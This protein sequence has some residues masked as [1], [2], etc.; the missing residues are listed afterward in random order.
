MRAQVSA[1]RSVSRPSTLSKMGCLERVVL[2]E[3]LADNALEV[4]EGFDIGLRQVDVVWRALAGRGRIRSRPG[5]PRPGWS[6]R[7]RRRR[8][9]RGWV[10]ECRSRLSSTSEKRGQPPLEEAQYG[11]ERRKEDADAADDKRA[12]SGSPAVPTIFTILM[13]HPM[14]AS[15]QM[16]IMTARRDLRQRW[17][18]GC[19]SAWFWILRLKGVE[20]QRCPSPNTPRRTGRPKAIANRSRSDGRQ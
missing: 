1:L 17:R 6:C 12:V 13:T 3:Q 11:T 7:Y 4:V 14:I 9:R 16:P 20:T 10:D 8:R 15:S 5:T 2:S 18:Y 19:W